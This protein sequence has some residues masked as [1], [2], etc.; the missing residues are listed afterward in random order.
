MQDNSYQVY[1]R[2]VL[3]LA[4]TLVIKSH[5][6][7][8]LL[9]TYIDTYF[10]AGL[11]DPLDMRTWKYYRNLCGEYYPTDVIMKV[12]SSDTL[13]EI[14]FTKENLQVHRNTA[15]DYRYGTKQYKELVEQFP[16][17]VQLILGI[18][19]PIEMETLLAA[20]DLSIVGHAPEFVEDHE[21]QLIGQLNQYVTQFFGRWLIDGFK[22]TDELY[23]A[24]VFAV[25]MPMMPAVIM[26]ARAAAYKTR[27]AH[28]YHVQQYLAS[29][30]RVGDYCDYMTRSQQM[31][32]YRNISYIER[33]S[34]SQDNFNWMIERLLNPRDIP[35]AKFDMRH[36]VSNMPKELTAKPYFRKE[37]LNTVG[38]ID[39]R[40]RYT[41]TQL[42]DVEEKVD[43]P[44]AINRESHYS[45][46]DDALTYAT[47]NEMP[48]KVFESTIIDYSD[49]EKN[50][51]GDIAL[52][53]WAWLAHKGLYTAYITFQAPS[54]GATIT[55]NAKDAFTLYVYCYINALGYTINDVPNFTL[56]KVCRIPAVPK[57]ALRRVCGDR[58]E[59]FWTDALH[60]TMP[61]VRRCISVQS[62]NQYAT[63]LFTAAN[64]QWAITSQNEALEQRG[65]LENAALQMWADETISLA[66]FSGQMYSNWFTSRN[67]SMGEYNE[68]EL[69]E[70]AGLIFEKISGVEFNDKVSLKNVQKAMVSLLT[71]LSSYSIQIGAS[72]NAGPIHDAG[73]L[74]LRM[75]N[76]E[77]FAFSIYRLKVAMV[78]LSDLRAVPHH[79]LWCNLDGSP[80]EQGVAVKAAT[81]ISHEIPVIPA[82]EGSGQFN[83]NRISLTTKYQSLVGLGGWVAADPLPP[84]LPPTVN[85]PGLAQWH[86]MPEEYRLSAQSAWSRDI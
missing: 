55:V 70:I 34:G 47:Q 73:I 17:Q 32:A 20:D 67:L 4:G 66:D 25:L 71:N 58:V 46:I 31:F 75:D 61:W 35:I 79:T 78:Y 53:N 39:G 5:D 64:R 21:F 76:F 45:E 82:F 86:A 26:V 51:W 29:H 16:M 50:R 19:Y 6:S 80:F 37:P 84:G 63:E 42:L 1:L 43:P 62:F 74:Q 23:L 59:P 68:A 12:S 85:V 22:R 44:N 27:F 48:T 33:N 18:V 15:L 77:G 54:S 41:I 2:S 81:V 56:Q 69:A 24:S 13:E 11:Y 65:Q 38:N 10:G 28:S 60:E 3:N 36:D 72:I 7:A 57:S 8:L 49:S 9:N 40:D 14:E 52:N 83:K 30:S